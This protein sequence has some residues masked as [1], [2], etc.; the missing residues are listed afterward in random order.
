MR[1]ALAIKDSLSFAYNLRN[2]R[3]F[4]LNISGLYIKLMSPRFEF[5]K[6]V[7]SK[8]DVVGLFTISLEKSNNLVHKIENF[9]LWGSVLYFGN[10]YALGLIPWM[11]IRDE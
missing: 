10:S 9:M 3:H 7:M 1:V 2:H 4:D 11:H 6:E 5:R 8:S